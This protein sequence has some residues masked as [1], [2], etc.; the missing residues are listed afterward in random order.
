MSVHASLLRTIALVLDPLHE[1]LSSPTAGK[2]LFKSLGYN[3][4][5][6][7]EA[8]TT[9]GNL[10]PVLNVLESLP[11][12]LVSLDESSNT[13]E[14]IG[15]LIEATG[16]IVQAIEHLSELEAENIAELPGS[17]SLQET[18]SDIATALPD[19]LLGEYL[20][21][22]EPVV[23][24]VFRILGLCVSEGSGQA[25]RYRFLWDRLGASFSDPTNTV[26]A[27]IGWNDNFQSWPLQRELSGILARFGAQV[28]IRPLT[29]SVAEAMAGELVETPAGTQTN[30]ILFS[31]SDAEGELSELG[32]TMAFEPEN[33]GTIFIGNLAS[34]AS[35]LEVQVSE[36]WRLVAGG[37]LDGTA[38]RGVRIQPTGVTLVGG[39]AAL[40]THI[41][42]EGTPDTPWVLIG[43]TGG[44]R[45]E[46]EKA[47]VEVGIAG[48]TSEPDGYF[49]A[50]IEDGAFRVIIELGNA[51]GFLKTLIGSALPEIAA[52]GELRWGTQ[53]GISFGGGIGLEVTLLI[54]KQLGPI[55]IDSLTVGIGASEAGAAFF[56]STVANLELGPF[57]VSVDGIGASFELAR[58]TDGSQF[59]N[60]DAQLRFVSPRGL[61]LAIDIGPVSGGGYLDLDAENGEYAG[62]FEAELFDV[63]VTVVGIIMT[64]FPDNPDGWSMFLSLSATFTG[65]QIGFGFTLNGVGGLIGVNR[66][67]DEEALA[68]GVRSGALDSIL[69][70][71]DVVANAPRILADM[72]AVFPPAE[73]QFVFGPVVKLG[74]GTPT[75]IEADVGVIVQLPEL[76]H[77]HTP[78]GPGI[79][80]P[81]RRRTYRR[82]EG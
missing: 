35:E 79:L 65:L 69:F 22:N 39:A 26:K 4:T 15:E 23:F 33:G 3:V 70:P 66:G 61:G 20:K 58:G 82:T 24:S 76:V 56:A 81:N 16:L 11:D 29:Q 7:P 55:Y 62:T 60:L 10:L 30:A 14:V 42:L 19:H 48:T 6:T 71:E 40:G 59:A 27:L 74:W 72:A 68:D 77:D 28:Y 31:Q 34:G 5:L 37:D 1:A 63:G 12:L 25:P 80:A 32:I 45:I 21:Y 41:A 52:G 36:D 2:R 13:G 64:Q 51:D 53:S 8:H 75:L 49:L 43:S 50:R 67:L 73:G 38:T 17:L 47:R 78:R 9:I 44:T 18:W 46:L 54:G 57:T